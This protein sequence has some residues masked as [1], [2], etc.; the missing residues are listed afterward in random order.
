MTSNTR[1]SV[2]RTA[3]TARTARTDTV[4]PVASAGRVLPLP[5]D[6][7]EGGPERRGQLGRRSRQ[8]EFA[9]GGRRGDPL[10]QQRAEYFG[11]PLGEVV[12]AVVPGEAHGE[13][14]PLHGGGDID[15]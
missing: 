2:P 5:P 14:H 8:G 7:L 3:R 6:V 11:L 10:H 1:P 4:A 12:I 9:L 13:S 15:R